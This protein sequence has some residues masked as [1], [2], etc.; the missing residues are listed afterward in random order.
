MVPPAHSTHAGVNGPGVTEGRAGWRQHRVPSRAWCL[1][2][3]GDLVLSPQLPAFL[4][5]ASSLWAKSDLHTLRFSAAHCVQNKAI[6]LRPARG[7]QGK[8]QTFSGLSEAAQ[9]QLSQNEVLVLVSPRNTLKNTDVWDLP[10]NEW[11]Q[12]GWTRAGHMHFSKPP[13]LP[14]QMHYQG[15]GIFF[16]T[17]SF[18]KWTVTRA[19]PDSTRGRHTPAPMAAGDR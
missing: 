4:H 11:V 10:A 12:E 9:G 13:S 17:N 7:T 5:S 14:T 3:Q 8:D 15:W 18:W 6:G 19:V 2:P 1:Y 16:S